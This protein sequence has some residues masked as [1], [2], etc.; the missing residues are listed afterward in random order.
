[1]TPDDITTVVEMSF[2]LTDRPF[3][4]LPPLA[5]AAVSFLL[6]PVCVAHQEAVHKTVALPR[7]SLSLP[8]CS[9]C[10][11]SLGTTCVRCIASC[12][13]RR[14]RGIRRGG[15][16]AGRLGCLRR[17]CGFSRHHWMLRTKERTSDAESAFVLS[18]VL[19]HTVPTAVRG[20]A[21][22]MFTL[23][24]PSSKLLSPLPIVPLHQCG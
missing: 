7:G 23:P 15:A 17:K 1:M 2:R 10:T 8:T 22:F 20:H 9:C 3:S 21:F 19:R 13:R 18:A 12:S 4:L 24:F 5:G 11:C 16:R 14:R 6:L